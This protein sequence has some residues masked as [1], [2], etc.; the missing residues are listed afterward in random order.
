MEFELHAAAASGNYELCEALLA[1]NPRP[2]PNAPD[3]EGRSAIFYAQLRGHSAVVAL[4]AARGWTKMPEGNL[5]EGPG[6][7]TIWWNEGA[8]GTARPQTGVTFY[9]IP[10]P[11]SGQHPYSQPLRQNAWKSKSERLAERK[12]LRDQRFRQMSV[13]VISTLPTDRKL[14]TRKEANST[15]GR[16][17]RRPCLNTRDFAETHEALEDPM[18]ISESIE[19]ASSTLRAQLWQSLHDEEDAATEFLSY[20]ED[21]SA[22]RATIGEVARFVV[23]RKPTW[24][25]VDGWVVLMGIDES[26]S[27][28]AICIP[29]PD[30]EGASPGGDSSPPLEPDTLTMIPEDGTAPSWPPLPTGMGLTRRPSKISTGWLA[31]TDAHSEMGSSV[32]YGSVV[33]LDDDDGQSDTDNLSLADSLYS[34]VSMS[35]AVEDRPMEGED[36]QQAADERVSVQQHMEH[37]LQRSLGGSDEGGVKELPSTIRKAWQGRK[38]TQAAVAFSAEASHTFQKRFSSKPA[39]ARTCKRVPRMTP[40]HH[41]TTFDGEEHIDMASMACLK[42]ARHREHGSHS[43]S[44]RA[45]ARREASKEKRAA[46]RAR[47]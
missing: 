11:S 19:F 10:R 33:S 21:R 17:R 23:D 28:P 5:H 20:M 32:K 2:A 27:V 24:S 26:T 43:F 36:S 44:A 9:S 40:A 16:S 47:I 1:E 30:N 14:Y 12:Q 39:I 13:D 4:L 15:V 7:R 25:T 29:L 6:G 38:A 37:Q 18:V 42:D 22:H 45:V 31:L 8:W 41:E 34:I 35:D 46:A 3:A